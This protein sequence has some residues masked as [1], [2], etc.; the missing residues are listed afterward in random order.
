MYTFVWNCWA[1]STNLGVEWKYN[2]YLLL[3]EH[4]GVIAIF[5]SSANG[6]E[7]IFY[8][9]MRVWVHMQNKFKLKIKIF[10]CKI[11]PLP[12][13]MFY[14]SHL[15]SNNFLDSH[16]WRERERESL[17]LGQDRRCRHCPLDQSI[18]IS[19]SFLSSLPYRSSHSP[20]DLIAT[21]F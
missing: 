20:L 2:C 15:P 11:S 13:K 8:T 21:A 12:H 18:V 16:T 7:D 19:F 9:L 17:N 1:F 6:I 3:L 4:I 10:D 14:T 5:V